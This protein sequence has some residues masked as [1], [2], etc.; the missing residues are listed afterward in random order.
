[1]AYRVAAVRALLPKLRSALRDFTSS[2]STF[3][4]VHT[5]NPTE[6]S[7][8]T[9]YI[10][11]SS[12]NPPSVAHMSLATSALRWSDSKNPEPHRLLLLFS[13]HNADKAPSPASFEHRLAMMT[14]F[15]EDLH[16]EIQKTSKQSSSPWEGISVDIGLT[17]APYYTDKTAA[18]TSAQ[19]NPYPSN[20]TH[21]HLIGFDTVTRLLAPKYYP[22]HKPPLSALSPYFE[23]GHK[24]LVTIRPSDPKDASS[25]AFGT[26]DQQVKYLEGLVNGRLEEEGFKRQWA[27]QISHLIGQ[28]GIGVSSTRIRK[29][30]QEQEWSDLQKLCTPGVAAWVKELGLYGQQP[31]IA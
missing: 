28:E 18:I 25:A 23:A 26:T 12:F 10:L 22:S 2:P 6:H 16:S 9:L 13:T 19:P 1:M 29:A 30:A 8:K 14:L 7:P 27:G 15:A 3:R 17:K 24:I 21:V 4:I 31:N 5:S 11:D 20:P